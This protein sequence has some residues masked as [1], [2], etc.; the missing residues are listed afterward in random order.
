MDAINY[1]DLR[2]NLKS[3][4]DEVCDRHEPVIITRRNGDKAVLISYEDYSAMEET[5]YLLR[6]PAM[7]ARLREGL[8]SFRRGGGE[9]RA[10]AEDD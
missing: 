5:A 1:S 2:G 10:L 8:D 7:A 4:L 3:V 9:E 6:S